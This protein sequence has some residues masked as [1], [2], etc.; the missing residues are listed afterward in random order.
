MSRGHTS[1]NLLALH[2]PA[3]CG[4]LGL[5][6]AASLAAQ[7][8]GDG[9]WPQSPP[10]HQGLSATAWNDMVQRVATDSRF[11]HT[12][13][14]LVLRHGTL[15]GE[16]YFNGSGPE[17]LNDLR[18]VTKS[19]VSMTMG[20]AI[21]RGEVP[22]TNAKIRDLLPSYAHHLDSL[23]SGSCEVEPLECSL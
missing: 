18:S 20:V 10:G 14:L 3:L 8:Q 5:M 22:R 15:I 19:V 2:A 12:R 6:L 9:P 11:T 4:A 21:A 7:P 23:K 17:D 16:A 1:R 13:A